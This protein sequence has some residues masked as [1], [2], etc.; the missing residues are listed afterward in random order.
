MELKWEPTEVK[1][2]GLQASLMIDPRAMGL[3]T[4]E[5]PGARAIAT[6]FVYEPD[7]TDLDPHGKPKQQSIVIGHAGPEDQEKSVLF[8]DC[9]QPTALPKILKVLSELTSGT[10][11]SSHGRK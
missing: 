4:R 10:G 8:V 3:M 5:F 1:V 9:S 2:Q 6:T 7:S 11:T